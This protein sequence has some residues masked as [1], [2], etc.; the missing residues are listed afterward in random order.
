MATDPDADRVGIGVK[1]QQGEF[2]L[3]NGNQTGSLL[4]Y[5]L[6]D[7]WKTASKF[8]GNEY[9]V[10]TIVTTDLIQNIAKAYN[11]KSYETLTGFKFIASLIKELEG[12]EQFIAGGEESYGYLIGD[13]VRDKDA[14]ASCLLI[15]EMTAW[16]KDKGSSLYE[17]MMEMHE[18]FGFYREKLISI[19]KQGKDGAEEIAKM[20]ESYRTNPPRNLANSAVAKVFD[21]QN[22]TVK[23]LK[24]GTVDKLDYQKSNVLQFLTEDGTKVS[25]RPSGTEPKIKFYFSVNKDFDG[26]DYNNSEMELDQKIDRI[27]KDLNLN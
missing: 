8:K 18:K 11:V 20:M 1:N 5:Y 19:T 24:S 10:K 14:V 9:V 16:A 2:V 3:L 13:A 26:S 4:I 27:I 6:L 12:K 22:S 7:A 25:A 21:Y 15:A 23:N 17:V